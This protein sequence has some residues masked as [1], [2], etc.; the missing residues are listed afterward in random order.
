[1]EGKEDGPGGGGGKKDRT[2]VGV[3]FHLRPVSARDTI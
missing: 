2:E 3:L 1:M